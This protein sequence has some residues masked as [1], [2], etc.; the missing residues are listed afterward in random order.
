VNFDLGTDQQ[1]IKDRAAMFADGEVAPRA[2]QS[3]RDDLV[4][5]ETLEKMADAGFMGLCVPEEYSG[6]GM[7]FLSYCLLIEEISRA[8]AGV[9]VTLAVH[10]SAGT[11]PIVMFGTEEQKSR[12]VPPLARGERI[13]CFAL[14]EPETGSDASAIR[15]RAER[16]EGGYSISGHKQWVTNGRVAGTMILFA[17]AEGGARDGV[18]AFVV[19][20]DAEGISFGKHAQKMGV[21]SATT[22][23]VLFDNVFV[24]EEDRL[25]EEGRGLRVALGTLDTGRIG[26]AA[27]A[28]GIAEA[29]F[30][31]AAQYAAERTTFG[32]PIAEH[33]AI[34][35]KLADMQTRIGAARLL[36]YEAAWTKDQ[37]MPH[38][39]A[40]ARA[41]LYA[42]QVANEV[43]YE[44]VQILGGRGYMKDHPVER[45]YRDARVT[46]I[47]EGTSEIQ[48]LV[49]SRAILREQAKA[50]GG[51][52]QSRPV[53]G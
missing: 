45:Y 31:Y 42:S 43:A 16:V 25:G 47:Y 26:I 53:V 18:T 2:T 40:G 37:E 3:D 38:G 13:G 19:S 21:V 51:V 4:P 33:Q 39:E 44:A 28:V 1:E 11:L 48:R 35:F 6:S 23:D 46:E 14:T 34:A 52:E 29:A 9:G 10:T 7:D 8:D 32:K 50:P 27:Q 49:I 15:T 20:M 24:P 5:F 30:R 17:R 36:V 12:W 22:D 41:K